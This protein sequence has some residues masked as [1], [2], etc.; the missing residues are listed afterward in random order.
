[1]GNVVNLFGHGEREKRMWIKD[2]KSG[3]LRPKHEHDSVQGR[4][5]KYL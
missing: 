5:Q 2:K 3:S 1:M 4:V